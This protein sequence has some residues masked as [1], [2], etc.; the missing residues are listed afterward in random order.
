MT[1]TTPTASVTLRL[2]RAEVLVRQ[3][4]KPTLDDAGISFEQWQVVAALLHEPGLG[5][6]QLAEQAALPAAS[7]TRH[8]DHLV[9]LALVIRRVD[10][11]DKRRAVT[12][13]SARGVQLAARLADAERLVQAE[14]AGPFRSQ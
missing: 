9:D 11:S 6:T 12:A 14:D 8:V 7:L 2:K 3:A 5:M 13:L 10:P 1:K 4:L